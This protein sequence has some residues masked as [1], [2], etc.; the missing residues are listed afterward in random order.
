M[1]LAIALIIDAAGRAATAVWKTTQ[2][3]AN[4]SDKRRPT[5]EMHTFDVVD[6]RM[7]MSN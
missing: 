4:G 3:M 6:V 5:N 1:E 2:A 7:I